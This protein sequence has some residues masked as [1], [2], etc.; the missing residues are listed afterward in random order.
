MQ[1]PMGCPGAGTGGAKK[2]LDEMKQFAD[3]SLKLAQQASSDEMKK[4]AQ[5]SA[6]AAESQ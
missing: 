6:Q 3:Q 2:L 1:Q 4:M 5:E